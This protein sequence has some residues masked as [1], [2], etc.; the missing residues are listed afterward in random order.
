LKENVATLEK[1][2][3]ERLTPEKVSLERVSF[4]FPLDI[5]KQAETDGEFHVVG[6]AATTDFDLQGDII[7]EEALRASQLDL[8]KNSTVLL[9]HDIKIPIGKV[10]KAE[11]DKNGRNR[12]PGATGHLAVSRDARGYFLAGT[13]RSD[14]EHWPRM[15]ASTLT[16]T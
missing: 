7:T 10:T 14:G 13:G 4:D 8:V 1:E 12:S 3:S 11:F 5:T 2:T 16:V 6:Y 9:N 15:A